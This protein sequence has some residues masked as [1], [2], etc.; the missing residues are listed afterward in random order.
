MPAGLLPDEGIGAL[1]AYILSAPILG[2]T[3]W[4]LVLWVNDF[5]PDSDTVLADLTEAT[6]TGYAR[7]QLARSGWTVPEVTMGCARSTWGT[8]PQK[9]DVG[10]ATVQTNYGVA[11]VDRSN[12][13]LRYVQRFDEADIF[14]ITLGGVF[15]L[16]PV[17]TLTSAECSSLATRM[18][19]TRKRKKR[20]GSHG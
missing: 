5:Y 3:S 20:K 13:V 15:L 14:P 7:R 4:D 9:Y 12:G 8:E 6:W 16:L 17:F 1:T 10:G 11:Y 2:V 18:R 19:N